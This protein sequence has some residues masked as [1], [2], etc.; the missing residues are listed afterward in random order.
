MNPLQTMQA[1]LPNLP[2]EI[3]DTW[4]LTF[5]KSFGWPPRIDNEWRYVLGPGN[6]RIFLQGLT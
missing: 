1:D 4:H 2:V 3:I 6:D 5:Y